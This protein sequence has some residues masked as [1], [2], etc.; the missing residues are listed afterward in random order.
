[1]PFSRMVQLLRAVSSPFI[2]SVPFQLLSAILSW[3]ILS[4]LPLGIWAVNARA[5]GAGVRQVILPNGTA[6]D[7][8]GT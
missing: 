6:V 4:I 1:M 7:I 5:G 3:R 8:P 2:G